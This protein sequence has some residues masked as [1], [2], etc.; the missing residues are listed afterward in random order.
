MATMYA[1]LITT[2]IFSFLSRIFPTDVY[3]RRI[4]YPPGFLLFAHSIPDRSPATMIA[5][6]H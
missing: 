3:P 5:E 2:F 6:N 1:T 4:F